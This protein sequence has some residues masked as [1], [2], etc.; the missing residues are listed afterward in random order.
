MGKIYRNGHAYGGSI[1]VDNELNSESTN[2]VQNKIVTRELDKKSDLTNLGTVETATATY[3]HAVGEYFVDA[4]GDFVKCTAVIAVGDTIAVGTNVDKINVAGITNNSL[5]FSDFGNTVDITSY[6]KNN[7]YTFQS[8][9]YVQWSSNETNSGDIELY[10]YGPSGGNRGDSVVISIGE[11]ISRSY[12]A[13]ALFVFK[14]MR[15]G[16]NYLSSGC[17][18][19]FM[20]IL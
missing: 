8:N 3:A 7:K 15:F 20:P 1:I 2:P 4:N 10:F 12:Q 16:Y 17:G 5:V 19:Y 13:G 6:S 9:G 11:K 14:G 18:V